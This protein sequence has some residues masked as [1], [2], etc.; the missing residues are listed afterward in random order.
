MRKT[1]NWW[2]SMVRPRERLLFTMVFITDNQIG[3]IDSVMTAFHKVK[4][5]KSHPLWHDLLLSM[6]AIIQNV[7]ECRYD[8]G[9]KNDLHVRTPVLPFRAQASTLAANG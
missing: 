5:E 7:C 6:S 8:S 4:H 1:N 9:K 2:F 3:G